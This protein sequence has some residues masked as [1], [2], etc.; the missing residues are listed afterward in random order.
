MT[1]QA[2]DVTGIDL[3]YGTTKYVI[4][5]ELMVR[6]VNLIAWLWFLVAALQPRPVVDGHGVLRAGR[7]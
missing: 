6:K 5:N 7:Y 2:F 1:P 3:L 4:L